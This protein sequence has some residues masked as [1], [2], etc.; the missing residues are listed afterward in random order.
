MKII[1]QKFGRLTVIE[2][3]KE[4]DKYKK[5]IYKCQCDCGNITYVTGCNLR[6]CNTKSCG[7]LKHKGYTIKHGKSNTRLYKVYTNMKARCYNKNNPNYKD[8]G[9]RGITICED[10]LNDFISFYNWSMN[11]GYEQGLQIDRID[12]NK[13]Y[14]P[15]NCRW[16]DVKTQTNNTRRNVLIT[17]NGKTQ[18]MAQWADELNL[19]Y[20]TIIFRH[21]KGYTDKECLFGKEVK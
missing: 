21:R 5:R 10:W 14:E 18:S 15:N 9:G 20:N 12:N 16:V 19:S 17:Y 1:G 4:R 13:G 6:N 8:W 2:E 7:C 11:N 3:C